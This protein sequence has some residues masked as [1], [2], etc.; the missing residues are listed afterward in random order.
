MSD[1]R[2]HVLGIGNAIVDV[3]ARTD[4]A[5]LESR[6]MVKGGMTLIDEIT[7]GNLY[8]E[9]QAPMEQSGGS[10]ANTIAAMAS[11]GSDCAFIG[12]VCDDLLGERFTD[13][14]REIGVTFETAPAQDTTS[15]ARCLI[16]VTPDAQRT[17]LT[18]LGTCVELG[19]RDIDADMVADAQI[20]YLEGYLWDPPEAKEAFIRAATIA[21]EAGNKVSLSLSDAFC[22]DRHR[23]DFLQLLEGHVDILFANEDEITSLYQVDEF[24]D[25]L[26]YVRGH[27]EIAALTRSENGSVIVSGDEIHVID[28]APVT[29]V[30]DTTGAGD[31]Y[32]A[33]FL[34]GMTHHLG[35]R[36]A[37]HVGSVAAAEVISHMGAR[38]AEPLGS[39]IEHKLNLKN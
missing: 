3:L 10:A 14:I 16:F 32:A 20:T 26:Q 28:A 22:V 15:T 1:K 35:L 38:P 30:V 4:D 29:E 13:A 8:G 25:A 17:M 27:C 7:A 36:D 39:L 11:L 33:G 31:A 5:F 9:M 2:F 24:D 19:P 34:Y 12:K 18:Y 6:E 37:A 21:H 23:D